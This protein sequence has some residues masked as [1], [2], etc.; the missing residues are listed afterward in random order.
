M[1]R[2]FAVALL[3]WSALV[4][5][6]T[7]GGADAAGALRIALQ[8]DAG[9]LD[10]AVGTSFTGRIV[11]TS[12]CDKLIDVTPELGYVPQLATAWAWSADRLA[13]DMTLRPGVT[14]HDGEAFDAE[15]VK[16]NIERYKT[17]PFSVR[18]AELA[19]V[20]AVEVTGPLSVRF[21]LSTPFAPLLSVLTDRAGMMVSP[22]AAQA[23]GDKLA[24]KPVCAGPFRFVENVVNDR[25]VLERFPQHWNAA[26]YQVDRVTFLPVPDTTV[27][28]FNL[29][30]GTVQLVD[31][32]ATTDLEQIRADKRVKLH[33]A[34]SIG[35]YTI[36]FNTGAGEAGQKPFATNP[37]LREAFE[38]AIDRAALNEVVFG[39]AFVPNNQ[40]VLPDSP[41]YARTRPMPK[42]DLA[43]SKALVAEAQASGGLGGGPVRLRMFIG[44]DT[45]LQRVAQV[46][47]AMVAEAGFDLQLDTVEGTTMVSN[48]SKGNF[49]LAFAIWSG[50]VDPDGNTSVWL[51]CAGFL[52]WGKYCNQQVDEAL[53][54]ARASTDQAER[55]ALYRQAA[56]LYLADRPQLFLYHPKWLWAAAQGLDGFKPHPDGLIRLEGVKLP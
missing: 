24:L 54:K 47:Q 5:P 15:A 3:A 38:L 4:A 50:R 9:P 26:A 2:A 40:P 45:V 29:L 1:S 17:A 20:Q 55:A 13:L 43:R 28:L 49:E 10:P 48:T 11:F 7:I 8:D 34:T 12:L 30:S 33:A 31:R 25:T 32:V 27:R 42:R 44:T 35:Y 52:N 21:R 18:K 14:F 37:R 41:Y 51:S 23:A 22:K 46:I 16:Y 36:V 19:P 6:P 39:G 56:E 53:A